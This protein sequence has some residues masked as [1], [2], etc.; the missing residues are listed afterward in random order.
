MSFRPVSRVLWVSPTA[1]FGGAERNLMTMIRELNVRGIKSMVILPPNGRLIDELSVLGVP[2]IVYSATE[3]K[4]GQIVRVMVNAIRLWFKVRRFKPD[5]IHS[6]SIF[7]MYVP[8]IL[9][10]M[11]RIRSVVHWADFDHRL[12][13]IR[14]INAT[15]PRNRVIAVSHAIKTTLVA[16]GMNSNAIEVIHNGTAVPIDSDADRKSVLGAWGISDDTIILGITGRIDNWKGH[17][18]LLQ[19]LGELS[20]LN[21]HLIIMGAFHGDYAGLE[22]ELRELCR[23]YQ[24]TDRV[25][26]T[27]YQ[28]HPFRIVR[29]LDIVVCPSDYEPF[30]LVAIE[31]MACEKPVIATATGGFLE[32]VV[33]GETGILVPCKT[34]HPIAD[35]IRQ[36]VLNPDRRYQ[37]GAAGFRRFQRWFSTERFIESVIAFYNR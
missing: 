21:I 9:G 15:F 4:S 8:V 25:T 17:R 2:T 23:R 22:S 6:N 10:A 7:C 26:F 29:H 13:D 36:L 31:A 5:I 27:G 1:D 37:L 32:T 14:L 19:A 35:A 20:D 34:V 12:G 16:H 18:Y 3:L 28:S 33:D 30:G 24:L 11:F